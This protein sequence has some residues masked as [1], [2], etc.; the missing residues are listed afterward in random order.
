VGFH[1]A[2]FA[3]RL[4]R[5]RDILAGL[6]H[7]G[8]ARLYDAGLDESGRPFLALEFVEGTSLTAYCDER[9]LSVRD[10]LGLF[11]KSLPR[12]ST[13]IQAL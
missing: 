4:C 5:E 12:S 10:R 7:P 9:R 13:R 3:E 8:I 2:Q 11:P 1:A 6:V